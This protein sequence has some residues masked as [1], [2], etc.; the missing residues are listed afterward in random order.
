VGV[1]EEGD[2]E[3]EP[4][5][6][7]DDGESA[8]EMVVWV[9]VRVRKLTWWMVM[10]VLVEVESDWRVWRVWGG[11]QIRG[12]DGWSGSVMRRRRRRV[13]A[14]VAAALGGVWGSGM[15]GHGER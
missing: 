8:G 9:A 7:K 4:G 3:E 14:A 12:L 1:D 13:E 10:G 11:S 5:G 2:Q 15:A 6:G